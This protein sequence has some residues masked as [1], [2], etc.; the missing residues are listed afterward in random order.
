[1]Q[2]TH[3]VFFSGSSGAEAIEMAMHLSYQYHVEAGNTSKVWF[4]SRNQSYHGATSGALSVGERPN[5][6]FID[7]FSHLRDLA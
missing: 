5:L 4:L 3:R 7:L 1:M 2:N 6:E